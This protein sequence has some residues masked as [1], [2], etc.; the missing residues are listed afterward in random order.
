M[1]CA[2]CGKERP[3]EEATR[4][5]VVPQAIGGGLE[6]VNPFVLNNV[7]T[8]CNRTAGHYIDGAFLRSWL[9]QNHR[10][11]NAMRYLQLTPQTVFPL[12]YNG[13]L[14]DELI[15]G[16][17]CDYWRGPT[18]DSIFHFHAPYPET[19]RAGTVGRPTYLRDE[20]IDAGFVF[21]FVVAT[22]PAWHIPIKNSVVANFPGAE[23]YLANGA[24]AGPF[25]AIPEP[26]IGIR[27][28]LRDLMR[29]QIAIDIPVDVDFGHRFLAKLALGMGALFLHA[30]FLRSDD[31]RLL[32]DAMWQKDS[33]V[34]AELPIAG[35]DF[36]RS[37]QSA[38]ATSLGWPFGHVLLLRQLGCLLYVFPAFFGCLSGAM[39]ISRTP[40][41]W[42]G[43]IDDD[44]TVFVIAPGLRRVVGP[45]G[46]GVLV[47]A[48]LIPNQIVDQ[49]LTDL[50]Q[51][52]E[53]IP[54]LPDIHVDDL[55]QTRAEQIQIVRQRVREVAYEH[56]Q[57][58]GR[59]WG[60]PLT[61]WLT[62]K[63]QLGIYTERV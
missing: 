20:Q 60:D 63:R 62:A 9:F 23:L 12:G 54:A 36:W 14:S 38:L 45:V 53:S 3:D 5:H 13:V 58:R 4:E 30:D 41:F 26:R 47:A 18:G 33:A 40:A 19:S 8:R 57:R 28:A 6:P 35:A 51:A 17:V 44:G 55:E 22:N 1:F 42:E 34:R 24:A 61:D 49:R 7:C 56:W 52:A 32:R 15:P 21:V 29:R 50:F 37:G 27:D 11:V 10:H 46:L 39:Q 48:R 25:R 31:A 59:P 43:R 16:M 2:Y